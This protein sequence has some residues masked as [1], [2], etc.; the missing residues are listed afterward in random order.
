MGKGPGQQ[1]APVHHAP[2]RPRQMVR[3]AQETG[4]NVPQLLSVMDKMDFFVKYP[5]V[6]KELREEYCH[7]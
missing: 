7:D 3:Q 6:L 1:Q 5:D 2:V 4:G